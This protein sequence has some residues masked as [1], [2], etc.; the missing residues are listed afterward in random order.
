[1]DWS[2]MFFQNWEGLART[3]AVGFVAYATLILFLRAS[4]AAGHCRS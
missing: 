3:V 1:M 2:Q 4:G